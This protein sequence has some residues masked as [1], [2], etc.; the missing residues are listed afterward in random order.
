MDLARYPQSQ[1]LTRRAWASWAISLQLCAAGFSLPPAAAAAQA[2]APALHELRP[3]P[4]L[5]DRADALIAEGE[6]AEA[7]TRLEEYLIAIPHDAEARWRAA[8][9]AVLVG[10]LSPILIEARP[11]YRK[12]IA[13]ADTVLEAVPDHPDALRWSMVAKGR[14]ALWTGARETASLAQDVWDLSH[15]ILAKDEQD[16]QAHHA[17]GVL[18]HKVSKLGR[19]QLFLGRLFLG[20]DALSKAKWEDALHHLKRAADLE[21]ENK[22][23]RLFYARALA[24]RGRTEEGLAEARSSLA[25]PVT[26]PLD[27]RHH[28]LLEQFVNETQG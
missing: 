28:H 4:T 13:H 19:V 15:Q 26:D 17:L 10:L 3:A 12:G 2:L 7:L 18:H 11:W 1:G 21:P 27:A 23:F 5:L 9:A 6:G 14:L 25:L 8:K 22:M 24:D 16:A 20:G